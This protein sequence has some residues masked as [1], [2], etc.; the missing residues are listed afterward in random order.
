MAT[1]REAKLLRDSDGLRNGTPLGSWK[2]FSEAVP[3]VF[4]ASDEI[5]VLF[6]FWL[7][8]EIIEHSNWSEQAPPGPRATLQARPGW[9]LSAAD[10]AVRSQPGGG[11]LLSGQI[12]SNYGLK[13][14]E[15]K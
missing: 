4:L 13:T 10:G 15:N 5:G 8:S 1:P 2:F 6:P 12:P 7:P 9:P 3:S 11:L 14:S